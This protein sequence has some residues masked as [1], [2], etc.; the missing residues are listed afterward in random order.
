MKQ[1]GK[2][3]N[4]KRNNKNSLS[5]D[6]DLSPT[7]KAPKK[8]S[9]KRGRLNDQ[10][11][12]DAMD[13]R[14]IRAF[15]HLVGA[16]FKKTLIRKTKIR[17]SPELFYNFIVDKHLSKFSILMGPENKSNLLKVLAHITYML[18]KTKYEFYIRRFPQILFSADELEDMIDEVKGYLEVNNN[19]VRSEFREYALMHPIT[20]LGK[21]FYVIQGEKDEFNKK[22]YGRR[23]TVIR[24]EA[25][26]RTK[27]NE[28]ISRVDVAR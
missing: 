10:T 21:Y 23:G 8:A 12:K 28:A 14:C 19:R 5:K 20:R 27:L 13:K 1:G 22:V 3:N 16:H 15:R 4:Y 17:R 2:K 18:M 9:P 6:T 24:N 25:E 7:F 11:R 26:F